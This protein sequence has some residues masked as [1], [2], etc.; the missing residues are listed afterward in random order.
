MAVKVAP[1]LSLYVFQ[2]FYLISALM[3]VSKVYLEGLK[4]RAQT[5]V[6]THI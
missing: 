2:A 6:Y 1:N 3:V 5:S 4:D